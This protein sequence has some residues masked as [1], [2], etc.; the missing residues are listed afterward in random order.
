MFT[1]PIAAAG[2]FLL[3]ACGRE[4]GTS[5]TGARVDS[6]VTEDAGAS[7]APSAAEAPLRAELTGRS[8]EI[9][10]PDGFTMVLL[11]YSLAG[12]QPPVDKWVE[13][14]LSVGSARPIDKPAARDALRAKIASGLA[15]MKDVGAIRLS[16]NA[17]LSEFDPF[18]NEYTVR[19]FAPSSEIQ[20]HDLGEQVGIKFD[21]A[22]KAQR[23]NLDPAQSQAIRDRIKYPSDVAVEALVKLTGTTPDPVGGTINA[24]VVEYELK[25]QSS[26]TTIGRVN[27]R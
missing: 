16:M 1:R 10:N 20:F 21:N 13:E 23:W 2:L 18:Y 22:Q 11:Y 26:G 15:A 19:A 6:I 4:D 8:R 9:S 3:S 7:A 17:G 5:P 24:D 12:G 27:V 14:H 25:S